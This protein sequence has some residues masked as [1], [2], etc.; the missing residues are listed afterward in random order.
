[1]ETNRNSFHGFLLIAIMVMVA[2][3][4]T[5][6]HAEQALPG[7]EIL[8]Y[9]V[10]DIST[11]PQQH[12]HWHVKLEVNYTVQPSHQ[13]V[14]VGAYIL[15]F[16]DALETGHSYWGLESRDPR[17][18]EETRS[19]SII[20]GMQRVEVAVR[21][22]VPEQS[23]NELKIF[24]YTPQGNEFLSRTFPFQ[25]SWKLSDLSPALPP[26]MK[27]V[28]TLSPSAPGP[29]SHKTYDSPERDCGTHISGRDHQ[30][31]V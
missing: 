10:I 6:A 16:G 17:A 13:K 28:G 26:G 11:T 25:R 19:G 14:I 31:T 7:D 22:N 30:E 4:A 12:W 2:S 9:R 23:T 24:L 27:V 15:P 3:I 21:L 5:S 1:M 8:G 29:G 20:R 18:V